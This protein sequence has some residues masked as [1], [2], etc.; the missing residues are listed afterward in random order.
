MTVKEYLRQAYRLD[1]RIDSDI[2]EMERLRDVCE[3]D[4]DRCLVEVLY[5]TGCRISEALSIK[6][7]EIRFDLPQPECKVLGKGKKHR[8]VY[9]SPRAVSTISETAWS[10]TRWS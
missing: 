3:N 1:H 7:A 10:R 4:R 9:F 2:A 5:S 8:I 6:V